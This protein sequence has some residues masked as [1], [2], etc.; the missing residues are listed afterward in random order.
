M[1]DMIE[2]TGKDVTIECPEPYKPSNPE[3]VV[4]WTADGKPMPKDSRYSFGKRSLKI[5]GLKKEDTHNYTCI[6]ENVAGTR[7]QTMHLQVYGEFD[8]AVFFR[9]HSAPTVS[10]SRVLR[11]L[12]TL[13]ERK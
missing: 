12:K 8:Y 1:K 2:F 13:K 9:L 10:Q 6:N 5:S 7:N 4:R 11:L 3:P